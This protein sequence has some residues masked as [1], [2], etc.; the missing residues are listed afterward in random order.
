MKWRRRQPATTAPAARAGRAETCS[1][2]RRRVTAD[3]PGESTAAGWLHDRCADELD[4]WLADPD[5]QPPGPQHPPG[6]PGGTV[7]ADAWCEA[8]ARTLAG[9]PQLPNDL[10]ELRWWWREA[11]DAGRAAARREDSSEP[12]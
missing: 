3:D 8:W 4:R 7:D 2:C 10:S 11:F 6:P 12:F 9:Y 5:K 1:A